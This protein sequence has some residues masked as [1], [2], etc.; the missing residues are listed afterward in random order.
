MISLQALYEQHQGKESDKWSLYLSEYDRL[1]VDYREQPVRLLEIGVQNGG[2][3]EIWSRYFVNAQRIVGCDINPDCARLRYED[4]RV[5]VV[6]GDASSDETEARIAAVCPAFDLVIDDGSHRSDDIVRSFVRYFRRLAD[7]GLYIAEDLHCSYWARFKGGLHDPASSMAFFRRLTDVVNHEHWGTPALPGS[8]LDPFAREYGIEISDALLGHIHSIEFV[9]SLCVIR[10]GAP[11]ANLLGKRI[12]AGQQ[13]AVVGR[14]AEFLGPAQQLAPGETDN[15]W[16]SPSRLP[17]LALAQ[18]RADLEALQE[19]YSHD[20]RSA[21][22]EVEALRTQCRQ[23]REDL[24][25]RIAQ[26]ASLAA[27]RDRLLKDREAQASLV[28]QLES[29]LRGALRDGEVRETLLAELRSALWSALRAGS[30]LANDKWW[31]RTGFLRNWS[32]S[33]RKLKGKPLKTWPVD[34]SPETYLRSAAP[35]AENAITASRELAKTEDDGI[36]LVKYSEISEDFVPLIEY[37]PLDTIPRAIAFYLPQFHPFDE[38]DAWWGKGFTEWTNVGKAK[39]LF[40]DHHQ[41]HCPIHLGY[42]DLRVKTVMEEQ[43]ALARAYGISGFAYYFYWFA[44]KVLM[45]DPLKQMLANKNVDMPFCMIWANENWT[46]RW[47]GKEHDVLI[48]QK[49][50]MEDSRAILDYLHPF[51]DDPRYIRIDGKPLFVIYRAD[52]IPELKETL[53]VW[54]AQAVSFGLPGLYIVCA[55]TFGQRDPR[56]FGFDAAMQ[57]PPHTV[58]SNSVAEEVDQLE[59]GFAGAIYDYD[60]AVTNAVQQRA[61]DYKVFP[62]AMLSWDNTARKN[63][64]STVFA[65]FSVNRYAQW[66]S[67]NAEFVAKDAK[68]SRDE[69]LVFVNAWNE[70]AEGTHLEPD[71]KYGYGYLAATR[72]VMSNYAETGARFLDPD[73]PESAR[74]PIAAVVHVHYEDTW[75]DLRDAIGRLQKRHLDLY[76]TATSLALAEAISKDF[77]MAI[78]ELVDNRG[79]DIRPFLRVLKKISGLGYT[80]VCKMHGKASTYRSD[81]DELRRSS[82]SVL[83]NGAN[84]ARFEENAGLGMLVPAESMIEHSE[85]NLTYSGVLTQA[86]AE[87]LGLAHWRGAFPAGSMFWF[88]PDALAPL[89]KLG[90]DDFDIER[91]LA[92]GTRAHAIERLFCAVC[93]SM[94]YSVDTT[95]AT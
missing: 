36:P 80:A 92:D 74:A 52:I 31:R 63:R 48:A 88:R 30:A 10:K 89:T 86:L 34:F 14:L 81:G 17:E 47:D 11:A 85:K 66:L 37:S 46:R 33:L 13:G 45:E 65:R 24:E 29:D 68:L 50:S 5:A 64:N 4:Q 79:R 72:S 73:Y 35:G 51:F 59:P 75:P 28:M 55:Q 38:N 1:F 56:K 61:E 2:S 25:R 57:F 7:G 62:T 40:R 87:E 70:W 8:V 9:N 78:V 53:N 95:L 93:K 22:I 60:Q 15:P 39:P 44:G 6:V 90:V 67:S 41:P 77:P 83:A 21:N 58:Q 27:E 20:L 23:N 19:R 76:V 54:R 32:N 82:L 71:Q 16:S 49:H 12:I 26:N 18:A 3:L 42:Y 43:A 94:G 84:I 69:K 91:G